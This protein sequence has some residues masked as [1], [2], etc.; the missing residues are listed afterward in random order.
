MCDFCN[1]LAVLCRQKFNEKV[2]HF[3]V[4]KGTL[5]LHCGNLHFL[6]PIKL[7]K[8]KEELPP[9]II[10]VNWDCKSENER[11]THFERN[12]V[13]FKIMARNRKE[14]KATLMLCLM[15]LEKPGNLDFNFQ[16]KRSSKIL[17]GNT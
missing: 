2:N 13:F 6:G 3:K 12:Y 10:Y 15:Q 17:L 9:K 1:L 14:I 5:G 16:P 4:V 11:L 7:S 8:T